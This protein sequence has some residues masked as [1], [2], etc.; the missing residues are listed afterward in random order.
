MFDGLDI[1]TKNFPHTFPLGSHKSTP[2]VVGLSKPFEVAKM[3]MF[4]V[5]LDTVITN[6]LRKC[7]V[8][9]V[10]FQSLS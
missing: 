10:E 8:I 3:Y 4:I 7:K 9:T 1:A 2:A 5:Y 6:H